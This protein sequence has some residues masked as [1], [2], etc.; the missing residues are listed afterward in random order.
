MGGRMSAIAD[1]RQYYATPGWVTEAALRI[2]P[3]DAP[4]IYDPCAGRG[5]ILD[6]AQA[7]GYRVA[8]AEIDDGRAAYCRAVKLAVETCDFLRHGEVPEGWTVLCNPPFH[9]TSWHEWARKLVHHRGPVF[10][11]LPNTVLS[12]AEHLDVLVSVAAKPHF[13]RK[14]VKFTDGTPSWGCAWWELHQWCD[15]VR[16]LV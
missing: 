12:A 9:G 15:G 10:M 5:H 6:V 4:G 2:V 1:Q 8:G 7:A 16:V 11:L 3:S 13:L 14:R